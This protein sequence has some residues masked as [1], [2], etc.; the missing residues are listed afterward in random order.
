ME[1]VGKG[2]LAPIR[3]QDKHAT[4]LK[5]VERLHELSAFRS[6]LPLLLNG[7]SFAAVLALHQALIDTSISHRSEPSGLS[8]LVLFLAGAFL[9]TIPFFEDKMSL[10][11]DVPVPDA[12]HADEW[13]L[14]LP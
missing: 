1:G 10:A 7:G 2:Q 11:T 6:E 9:A 8:A 14:E 12:V 13:A 4:W 3:D 5:S